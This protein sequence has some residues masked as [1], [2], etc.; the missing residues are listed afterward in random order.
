[1]LGS[2]SQRL[3]QFSLFLEGGNPSLWSF[4]FKNA[5]PA[6]TVAMKLVFMAL[7]LV[8]SWAC[9]FQPFLHYG[10]MDIMP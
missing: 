4:F 8:H 7:A 3:S 6:G 2:Y 1:M 10:P 5:L 9:N